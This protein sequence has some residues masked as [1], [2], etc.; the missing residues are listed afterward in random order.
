MR[1]VQ[2]GNLPPMDDGLGPVTVEHEL[3]GIP[4]SGDES[5]QS[6]RR[7]RGG[8][9]TETLPTGRWNERAGVGTQSEVSVRFPW[10]RT[11]EGIRDDGRG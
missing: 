1:N 11:V 8:R 5:P 3:G 9:P 6:R 2:V 7:E 4:N 10:R